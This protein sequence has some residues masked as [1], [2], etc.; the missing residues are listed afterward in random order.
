MNK[1]GKFIDK[2]HPEVGDRIILDFPDDANRECYEITD[3]FD[4]QLTQDGI[5]P[6]LGTYIWKCKARRYINSN[7]EV[8]MTQKD[9]EMKEKKKFERA[10]DN[11]VMKVI[12]TYEDGEDAAY[13][14]YDAVEEQYDQMDVDQKSHTKLEY[15]EPNEML[16]IHRF[17]CGSRLMT[18][19]YDL[20]FMTAAGDGYKMTLSER[21]NLVDE[22]AFDGDLRFLKASKEAVVFVNIAGETFK[23]AE[24]ELATQNEMQLC[25]NSLFDRTVDPGEANKEDNNFYVFKSSKTMLWATTDHLFCKLSSNGQLYR[26]V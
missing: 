12:S 10:I 4:K 15:L 1:I 2:I 6:L 26:L 22:V 14:G 23:L 18:N 17:G 16:D 8:G 5:S 21:P 7:D 24:D 20:F 9:K 25:L 3:C 13:G 11:E 19:G